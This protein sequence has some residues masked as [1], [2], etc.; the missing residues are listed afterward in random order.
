[1]RARV[2]VLILGVDESPGMMVAMMGLVH[3][4]HGKGR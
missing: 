3:R 1:M 4:D 2:G